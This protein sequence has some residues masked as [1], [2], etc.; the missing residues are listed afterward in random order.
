MQLE[1]TPVR[2]RSKIIA[3]EIKV[4]GVMSVFT[5]TGTVFSYSPAVYGFLTLDA[6]V[7]WRKKLAA[8]SNVYVSREE[9]VVEGGSPHS[10]PKGMLVQ[11]KLCQP[12]GGVSVAAA[13]VTAVGGAPL[14]FLAAEGWPRPSTIRAIERRVFEKL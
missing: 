3:K 6:A 5:V 1:Y 10:I 11:F 4:I 12:S 8:G 13:R 9:F 14:P 2:S 7:E